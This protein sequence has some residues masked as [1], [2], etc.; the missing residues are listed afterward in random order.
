MQEWDRHKKITMHQLYAIDQQNK[1]EKYLEKNHT[2]SSFNYAK[3]ED[4]NFFYQPSDNWTMCREVGQ[5]IERR[6]FCEGRWATSWS[7]I[8]RDR[9]TQW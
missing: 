1:I 9:A 4:G 6:L 2:I 8:R 7:Y 3:I 5:H